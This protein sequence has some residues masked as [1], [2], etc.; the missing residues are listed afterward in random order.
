MAL[1]S[2]FYSLTVPTGGGKTLS[3]MV[4]AIGHALANGKKRIIIAIP[5]TS[6]ITQTAE[7]LRGIFGADNVVEHHSA[8]NITD[9]DSPIVIT[10]NVQLFESMYASRPSKCRKLHNLCNS[11]LIL[12]EVQALP[13]GHLQPIVDALKAYQEYFGLS[14]LFTTASMPA[15]GG[16]YRGVSCTAILDGIGSI[17]EIIPDSFQLHD[18]LRRA[19]IRFDTEA[20]TYDSLA[21]RLLQHPRVW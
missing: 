12:D 14:V 19:E 3:S 16:K 8:V 1:P 7:V 15:L 4:W 21:G 17:T 2:G 20:T 6:V 18:H 5:Y 10:T 9:G 11:V 13:V